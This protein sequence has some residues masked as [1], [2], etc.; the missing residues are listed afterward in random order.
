MSTEIVPYQ[1]MERM[2]VAVAKSGLFAVKTPEAAI[3]LMMVAQSEGIHPAQAMMEYD[4]IQGK[5]SLKSSSMLA[6]FQRA[7]GKVEWIE[8]SDA[9][10]SGRFTH[11]AGGSV[12]VTW[13][14][15]R[16]KKAGLSG[17]D[18]HI[19]FPLQMKRARCI[20]E[21][22]R[23]VFP[24]VSPAGLYTPEETADMEEPTA[25]SV[26]QAINAAD[27]QLLTSSD[28]DEHI[29]AINNAQNPDELREVYTVA[30]RAAKGDDSRRN[31]IKNAYESRKAELADPEPQ[32]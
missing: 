27:G 23:A 25:V 30:Y 29:A 7:G 5:P 8:S 22:V 12:V 3:S 10:V 26:T 19:K 15:E 2:A 4:L 32:P 11:P 21:G 14:D 18:M 1:Q 28:R 20:S 16:V 17:K 13:D 24:G 31:T 9:K 6:R